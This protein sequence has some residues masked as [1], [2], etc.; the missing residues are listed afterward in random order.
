M[1]IARLINIVPRLPVR[2]L[3]ATL[4]FYRDLLEFDVDT[5]WPDDEPSFAVMSRDGI[6]IQFYVP[7][8]RSHGEPGN[9]TINLEVDDARALHRALADR[10]RIEWGP[11]VYWYGRREFAFR[12]PDGCLVIVT[13]QTDDPPTS[14]DG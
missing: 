9:A 6:T 2:D 10:V 14:S 11:E 3:L 13:E 12:D 4:A 1:T 5:A 7:D 8:T